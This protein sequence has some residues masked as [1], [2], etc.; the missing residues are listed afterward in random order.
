MPSVLR[1][2]SDH[3]PLTFGYDILDWDIVS[4]KPRGRECLKWAGEE[5]SR[6]CSS[7]KAAVGKGSDGEED[8]GF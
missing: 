3:K 6:R 4:R 2:E 8:L 5:D 1:S 7:G